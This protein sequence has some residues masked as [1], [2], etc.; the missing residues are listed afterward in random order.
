MIHSRYSPMLS[1]LQISSLNNAC[2]P[3]NESF[4][5]NPIHFD[6]VL[7]EDSSIDIAGTVGISSSINQFLLVEINVNSFSFNSSPSFVRNNGPVQNKETFD[8]I[9]TD[10]RMEIMPNDDETRTFPIQNTETFDGI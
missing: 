2:H 8:D 7:D 4:K 3:A 6:S 9:Q 1:L 5:E 10:S